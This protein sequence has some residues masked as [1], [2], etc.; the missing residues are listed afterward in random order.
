MVVHTQGM[1]STMKDERLTGDV[2]EDGGLD[3]KARSIRDRIDLEHERA[4]I[5][6]G[7]AHRFFVGPHTPHHQLQE[8]KKTE[9]RHFYTML[10]MLLAED[11]KYRALYELVNTQLDDAQTAT[12]AAL[13]KLHHAIGAAESQRQDLLGHAVCLENGTRVFRSA[14]NG[15][16]YTENGQLLSPEEAAKIKFS[17]DE[18]SWEEYQ[19][20]QQQIADARK[21]EA[22]V[23]T[24]RDTVLNPARDRIRDQDHP[25]SYD[26]LQELQRKLKDAMPQSARA[27]LPASTPEQGVH[28][29]IEKHELSGPNLN[30]AFIAAQQKRVDDLVVTSVSNKQPNFAPLK[31]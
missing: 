21:R 18:P 15:S 27:Y 8:K 29:S 30:Q 24:Y 6:T 19:R 13:V 4:G 12:D 14:I 9:E 5:D 31:L 20:I 7:R 23:Q 17:G 2:P 26:E 10:E 11:A 3:I 16:V 1:C 22:E 25:L 28:T